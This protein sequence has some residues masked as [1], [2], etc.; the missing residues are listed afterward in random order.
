MTCFKHS[1]HRESAT[2]FTVNDRTLGNVKVDFQLKFNIRKC[3]VCGG[4]HVMS[5]S[6]RHDRLFHSSKRGPVNGDTA[7][8][9]IDD[10]DAYC[11][12]QN[13]LRVTTS[14]NAVVHYACYQIK[15]DFNRH[16]GSTGLGIRLPLCFHALACPLLD[17]S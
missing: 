1:L 17:S 5:A 4:P 10:Q 9:I 12:Q 13:V 15:T 16:N 7:R 14:K 2:Q 3:C 8:M 11:K 6:G